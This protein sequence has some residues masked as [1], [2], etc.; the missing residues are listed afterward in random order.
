MK[1]KE[2][3]RIGFDFDKVFVSYPPFIPSSVIEFL[4]RHSFSLGF[5][6]KDNL[7]YRFPGKLEQKIRIFSHTPILRHPIRKN[8]SSL[9]RIS[10]KIPCDLYLVSSRY[11]FLKDRTTRWVSKNQISRYFKGLYFN[12]DNLQPHIFKDRIIKKLQIGEFIDDD[13]DLILYLANK[14]PGVDFFW[15]SSR[16]IKFPLPKNVTQIKNLRE[17]EFKK[18]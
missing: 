11:S 12:Y 17:F 15:V 10:E 1:K 7:S 18:I 4:Y 13:L 16:R 2:K 5:G 6:D 9:E 8:L 3:C 14:N